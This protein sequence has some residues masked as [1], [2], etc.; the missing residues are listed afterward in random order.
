MSVIAQHVFSQSIGYF[1]QIGVIYVL[2]IPQHIVTGMPD[3][4]KL[5][6]IRALYALHK[7]SKRVTAA[8]RRVCIECF[9]VAF[10]GRVIYIAGFKYIIK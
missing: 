10:L 7:G 8:M 3:Q 2:I 1:A 5:I 6:F 4:F 9:S